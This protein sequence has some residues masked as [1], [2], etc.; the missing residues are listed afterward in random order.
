MTAKR[1]ERTNTVSQIAIDLKRPSPLIRLLDHDRYYPI[2]LSICQRLDIGEIVALSRTCTTIS[3]IYQEL[4]PIF[5]NVNR[6]L[7]RYVQNPRNFRFQLA[8]N[9]AMIVGSFVLQFL[10]RVYWPKDALV[11]FQYWQPEDEDAES[12]FAIYLQEKEG[13]CLWRREVL[14][15]YQKFSMVYPPLHTSL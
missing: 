7:E 13:Y 6:S 2:F 14:P 3:T 4:L 8:V 5:W 1:N 10:D 12:E 11:I 15:S 9:D